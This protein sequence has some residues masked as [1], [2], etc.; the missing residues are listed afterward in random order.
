MS[1]PI[2]NLRKF[3]NLEIK[4]NY[5][6]RAIVGGLD[7]INLVWVKDGRIYN[8]PADLIAQISKRILSYSDLPENERPKAIIEML[9]IL[10][11][12]SP[13]SSRNPILSEN[14]IATLVDLPQPGINSPPSLP[15]DHPL[16]KESQPTFKPDNQQIT[17][18]DAPLT[19]LQG[20]GPS[21]ASMLK[22]LGMETL[23]DLLYF[24]PRR[25]DD[26]S[27]LKPINRLTVK[28]NVTII[29]TVQSGGT[30][31]RGKPPRDITEIIVSDG[32]SPLRLIWWNQTWPIRTYRPGMQVVIAGRVDLY[33][34]RFVISNP[35]IEQIEQE[36]L[37]T[38]RI[39]PVYPLTSGL[40][41]KA[42]RKMMYETVSF[43][44]PRAPEYLPDSIRD[45]AEIEGLSLALKQIHFPDNFDALELA[46][47][48]LAFDEIFLVQLGVLQ[49]KLAWQSLPAEKFEVTPDRFNNLV[50][51]LPFELTGSQNKVMEQITRD[52]ASTSPMNRLL[53]GDVGSGKTVIAGLA[54]SII[55]EN[56]AQSAILAP[57]SILAIQHQ[58]TLLRLFANN[59][60]PIYPFKKDEIRLLIG[61]TPEAEKAEIREHLASGRIKLLIG[62]HAL[63][64]EPVVFKNLKLAVIDE[65]HRF[66]VEQR[67]SL[68]NKGEN[69]HLL[70][71]TATPIPR[72]LALTVYGDLDVSIIDEMPVGRIPV[73]TRII[74]PL[75]R[76]RAYTFIQSQIQIGNQAFIVYPLIDQGDND[77][78]LSAVH[79][80]ERLQ[81][82]I[83]GEYQLGLL[84]GRLKTEEKDQVMDKFRKNEIQI[85][86]TTTV[87][88]VGVDIPN[89]TV[90]LIEAANR[91][92]L[93][94]LHQLRGRVGRG[95]ENSY[96]LLIPD[97][98]DAIENERLSVMVET[99]DG[100]ILAE[101]DLEQRGP[102][103]F[104]GTR[105]SGYTPLRMANLTDI[106]LIEKAR[107]EA[108]SLIEHDPTLSD[109]SLKPLIQKVNSFWS[110]GKGDIS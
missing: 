68:R 15:K 89:A 60:N 38:N 81:S 1:P 17:G 18:L 22:S 41:Q 6:N 49:Q 5:D 30:Y 77:E 98:E 53:Q 73:E 78:F 28:E 82:D 69:P 65:Q 75:E 23:E 9:E 13:S 16:Q 7:K 66:G 110:T 20:I 96:C 36:H 27:K 39:V 47:I 46:R 92:G 85:L 106:Q 3:L 56:G 37:H 71:M 11:A 4:R 35:D 94:Q 45:S 97:T 2:D 103:E 55:A 43:W 54:A 87:I 79:E 86:V 76:E 40:T 84:H 32:T 109:P 50:E 95:V 12:N 102:G 72:S 93:A 107:K 70:V 31:K 80:Y 10:N 67:A 61:D 26:Y 14:Q 108:I 29:A 59:E 88:E 57:T 44:A 52:L 104:L 64:E 101:K 8:L 83:F 33:L 42:V 51:I 63:L 91:F 34:G 100:F 21:K 62:T 58:N 25:Y 90:M 105:Q 24:F 99:N 48:R 74:Y 19:V